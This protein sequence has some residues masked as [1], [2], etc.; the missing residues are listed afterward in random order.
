LLWHRV[1]RLIPCRARMVMRLRAGSC[2]Q[3]MRHL[4]RL[5]PSP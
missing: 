5:K 4:A 2:K 3:A 1:G